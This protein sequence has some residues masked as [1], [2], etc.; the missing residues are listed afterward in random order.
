MDQTA[1][2]KPSVETITV[3]GQ[4]GSGKSSWV[5]KK[6]PEIPRFILWDTLG[7]YVEFKDFE[8]CENIHDLFRYVK[9]NEGGVFQAVY[10]S[11]E[12]SEIDHVCK[13]TQA[14]GDCYLIIEEVDN[15]ATPTNMPMELKKVLKYGRHYN[16]S[17]IFISRRPA[18]INRLITSQSQRF[19]CF[20]MFEPRD[21]TYLRS[22]MGPVADEIPK[23]EV[24]HYLDWQHGQVSYGKI[25]W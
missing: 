6:L 4:K 2:S 17:M 19:V 20:K 3:L 13:I 11:V 9:K 10:N 23:L 5:K 15:F 12:D 8:N 7:E 1:I 25:Q 24:L 21:I 14:V 18:E 22:I 16:I